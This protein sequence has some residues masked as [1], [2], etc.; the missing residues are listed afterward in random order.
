MTRLFV[1]QFSASRTTIAIAILFARQVDSVIASTD[2]GPAI[3]RPP[4]CTKWSTGGSG[5]KFYVI[6]DM[7]GYYWTGISYLNRCDLNASGGFNVS[8]SIHY[9]I[10]SVKNGSDEDGHAENRPSDVPAGEVGQMVQDQYYAWHARCWNSYSMGTEHEG[11]AS[12]PA[13]YSEP[14]YQASALL[15][16]SKCYKY[17][18]ARDRNHVVAH[19]QK[20]VAGWSTWAAAN[21]GIDPN[22]NTHTDPGQYWNWNHYMDLL[23]A[24]LDNAT[25]V[26][27][28]VADNSV[29]SP[30]QAF[31]CTW[32]LKNSGVYEWVAN[33]TA[34]CTFNYRTGTQMGAPNLSPISANVLPNANTTITVNFTAP[35]ASGI[36]TNNFQM[37][38]H[39]NDYFGPQFSLTVVVG[40]PTLAI[41]NQPQSQTKNPGQTATFSVGATGTGTLSY[42]WKKNGTNLVNGGNV[43]GATTATLSLSSVTQND[44]ATYKVQVSNTATNVTS[45]DAT[46]TVNAVTFFFDNFETNLNQWGVFT[47]ASSLAISTVTN[48]TS[49]GVN[50]AYASSTLNKMYHNLG[51]RLNGRCR[52]TFW[53]Y[54]G[55][56]NRCFGEIRAY[57]N[58][59]Y[60]SGGLN[61]LFAIGRYGVGFGTGNTG[62]LAGEVVDVN[63]Y[64]GRV[65]TGANTGWFNLTNAPNRTTGWHKFEIERLANGTNINFYV[66]GVLGRQITA[67]TYYDMDSILMGSIGSGST[68]G[69]GWIDDVRV[70]Y[71]DPPVIGTQPVSQAVNPAVN[72][73]FSVAA[74]GNVLSYQWKRNGTNI[75]GAT[76]SSYTRGS[77]QE[78][79]EGNYSVL[80]SN[81]AGGISS[82]NASLIVNAPPVITEQPQPETVTPGE[83]VIFTVVA[84]GTTPLAYQ[85]KFNGV[86]IPGATT[87]AYSLTN[88]QFADAGDYSVL[89]TN[90]AGS[91]LSS[92]ASLIIH[93]PAPPTF[94]SVAV[95]SNQIEITLSGE[96][97][98][99]YSIQSSTNLIDWEDVRNVILT[100]GAFQFTDP[101]TDEQPQRFYRVFNPY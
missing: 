68:A 9:L 5:K 7:E 17:N 28:T 19:G 46:L 3:Y 36:Y 71:F 14:M 10:N 85:W 90:I 8:V 53:I 11:F 18:I 6:H 52:V 97:G 62:T 51:T 29:I 30:G 80:V 31:S 60:N 61:Q 95:S 77:V 55:T 65:L 88:A 20:L 37:N 67:A 41:T 24:D 75:S 78:A 81:G 54:D 87:D 48:H 39:F 38:N 63:K 35:S 82:A 64:Q 79:D 74:T 100:N 56:L 12:S 58:G 4:S 23:N 13:W 1:Q 101:I 59:S 93:I 70:E 44:A 25:F 72:V 83:I 50:S 15:T 45:A 42:Q 73:T 43:S 89:V 40:T 76:N 27:K 26:S 16:S 57:A 49:G 22:C 84:T 92:P 33:G 66:D 2:Y 99:N 96:T 47:N 34:G 86:N 98:G 91:V 94:S 69:D 32:T 21:F